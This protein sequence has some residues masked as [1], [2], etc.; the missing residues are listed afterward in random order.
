MTCTGSLD[1]GGARIA[2]Q[3]DLYETISSRLR[4]I[5]WSSSPVHVD[6]RP[7]LSS[8]AKLDAAIAAHFLVKPI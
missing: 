3:Q 6:S 1:P 8:G 7:R 2:E 4:R 5:E